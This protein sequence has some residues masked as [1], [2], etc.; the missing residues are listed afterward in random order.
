MSTE[1][2]N[3]MIKIYLAGFGALKEAEEVPKK[4]R[5]EVIEWKA[6]ASISRRMANLGYAQNM[7]NA[8][9]CFSRVRRSI[10]ASGE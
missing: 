5:R 7:L 2:I 8:D 4:A 10:L 3:K 1:K 6:V 9:C